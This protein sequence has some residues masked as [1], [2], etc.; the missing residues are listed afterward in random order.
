[1]SAETEL[2]LATVTP[3]STPKP[4]PA[5]ED[6]NRSSLE[7]RADALI[8]KPIVPF[9]ES[10]HSP[11]MGSVPTT[12]AERSVQPSPVAPA[13]EEPREEDEDQSPRSNQESLD[14]SHLVHTEEPQVWV[15]EPLV[16]NEAVPLRY[17]VDRV[18]GQ[19]RARRLPRLAVGARRV[20]H[21]Q[22][23]GRGKK[24]YVPG[25]APTSRLPTNFCCKSSSQWVCA[26]RLTDGFHVL[27]SWLR[28]PVFVWT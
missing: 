23:R 1:M 7:H 13:V 27:C 18:N 25:R 21:G 8:E 14:A 26:Y 16:L 19:V 3:A 4:K 9:E 24:C 12:P 10:P 28:I 5:F 11:Q 6:S 20:L 15:L 17:L 2:D 22:R